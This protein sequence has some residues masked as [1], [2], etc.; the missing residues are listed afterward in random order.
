M[1][2][3]VLQIEMVDMYSILYMFC[4]TPLFKDQI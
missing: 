2:S 1:V 4:A 3:A